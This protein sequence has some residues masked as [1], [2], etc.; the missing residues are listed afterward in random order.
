MSRKKTT[1]RRKSL[2]VVEA[3]I[4]TPEEK[5]ERM[6]RIKNMIHSRWLSE[7]IPYNIYS[8]NIASLLDNNPDPI[9][10]L[11]DNGLA[12]YHEMM[13]DPVIKSHWNTRVNSLRN[14]EWEILDFSEDSEDQKRGAFAREAF[15][16][17]NSVSWEGN[18]AILGMNSVLTGVMDSEVK[19][20]SGQECLWNLSTGMIQEIRHRIPQSF[21]WRNASELDYDTE[22]RV[23]GALSGRFL[24]EQYTG[25]DLFYYENRNGEKGWRKAPPFKFIMAV[26]ESMYDNPHGESILQPAYWPW[27][28][29][30]TQ[31]FKFWVNFLDKWG[32]PTPIA[33][34]SD[35]DWDDD[36]YVKKILDAIEAFQSDYAAVFPKDPEGGPIIRLL[37]SNRSSSHGVYEG[38]MDK[39]DKWKA[40]V[41]L[42]NEL[43]QMEGEYNA[44]AAS[45]V[46][47]LTKHEYLGSDCDY[48]SNVLSYQ[49]IRWMCDNKFGRTEQT[50]Y[51]KFRFKYEAKKDLIAMA[52]VY[53]VLRRFVKIGNKQIKTEFNIA[54]I[55][56]DDFAIPSGIPDPMDNSFGKNP[57]GGE[58]YQ[59]GVGEGSVR[60]ELINAER[61]RGYASDRLRF[62]RLKLAQLDTIMRL[63]GKSSD[64][65]KK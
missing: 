30:Y 18:H 22:G 58:G 34:V 19:G 62:R 6:T 61:F 55:E 52:E 24:D 28:M 3:P 26:Y 47:F 35:S 43:S 51:P 45:E 65:R 40:L 63:R 59:G 32:Q 2:A 12:I 36:A 14:L 13:L 29:S 38:F 16:N 42:G 11:V 49:P 54:D 20:Y 4:E 17:V 53:D 60:D 50:K 44:R 25:Q 8:H 15:E 56:G 48:V 46:H 31:V 7:R 23:N 41:I 27:Y 33:E 1:S 64:R 10:A 37:E 9:Q 39:M 57:F 21:E 5:S